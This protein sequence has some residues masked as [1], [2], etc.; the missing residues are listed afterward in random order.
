MP[1]GMERLF[2]K[3]IGGLLIMS[4]LTEHE[5]LIYLTPIKGTGFDTL[6]I[7]VNVIYI[8]D[9]KGIKVKYAEAALP[10]HR[11][12]NKHLKYSELKLLINCPNRLA[13]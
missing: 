13:A 12:I 11:F 8:S 6:T 2:Y 10:E 1:I 3:L 9:D 4:D 5:K 7:P